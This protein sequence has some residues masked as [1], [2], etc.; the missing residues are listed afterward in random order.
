MT[1]KAPTR[2]RNQQADL[3]PVMADV[4]VAEAIRAK[5]KALKVELDAAEKAI[6]DA[7]GKA[8]EGVD[9]EGNVVVRYPE[10]SRTD[11]VKQRVRDLLS[12]EDYA[13]C[14]QVTSYRVLLFG[15]GE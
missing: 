12:D 6:K 1:T 5:V 4:R 13:Q 3:T 11:L 15:S 10:R 2:S 9:S 14:E 8:L 7:L